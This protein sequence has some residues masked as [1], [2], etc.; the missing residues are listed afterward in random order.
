MDIV[1]A[2]SDGTDRQAMQSTFCLRC[3]CSCM[4]Q[5]AGRVQIS[6]DVS[7][8]NICTLAMRLHR[9]DTYFIHTS[10]ALTVPRSSSQLTSMLAGRQ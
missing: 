9:D 7:A 6:H 10:S 2:T 8:L 1:M 4:P 5:Q 3:F